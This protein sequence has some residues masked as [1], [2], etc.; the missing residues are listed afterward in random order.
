MAG[1]AAGALWKE[2]NLWDYSCKMLLSY[3]AFQGR[4]K[5]K[6]LWFSHDLW[7]LY[8]AVKILFSA[9]TENKISKSMKTLYKETLICEDSPLLCAFYI[10]VTFSSD[11]MWWKKY[12]CRHLNNKERGERHWNTETEESYVE[13]W[14]NLTQ[15]HRIQLQLLP[16]FEKEQLLLCTY[17]YISC[18]W[19]GQDHS[20]IKNTPTKSTN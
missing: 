6:L 4:E 13:Q 8:I 7:C 1:Q 9:M 15:N 20:V 12:S 16:I 19:T 18:I 10:P 2:N 14:L 3:H 5:E 17:C 11:I